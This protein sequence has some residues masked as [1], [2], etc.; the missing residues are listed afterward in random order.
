M[1]AI[2][3]RRSRACKPMCIPIRLS[4]LMAKCS[5]TKPL[6]L[7]QDFCDNHTLFSRVH[8]PLNSSIMLRQS[9]TTP[10]FII[11]MSSTK[12]SAFDTA[13]RSR[14]FGRRFHHRLLLT[15]QQTP[16]MS[17]GQ[18]K[19]LPLDSKSLPQYRLYS[20]WWSPLM[21]ESPWSWASLL[22]RCFTFNPSSW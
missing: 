22:D 7:Y 3:K 10:M 12:D 21:D 13:R 18:H 20:P 1:L 11:C 8:P 5:Q 19:Q 16:P 4:S 15:R 17:L 6:I 2:I 9:D 14:T